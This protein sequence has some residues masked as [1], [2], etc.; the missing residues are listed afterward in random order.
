MVSSSTSDHPAGAAQSFLQSTAISNS[1]TS[2]LVVEPPGSSSTTG[3]LRARSSEHQADHT[4][5]KNA[6]L[7]GRISHGWTSS[8][9]H[10]GFS[11]PTE[12][13]RKKF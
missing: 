13:M 5:W 11:S 4:L 9:S 10:S 12:E 8:A 1:L 3:S 6:R 2:S 7:L